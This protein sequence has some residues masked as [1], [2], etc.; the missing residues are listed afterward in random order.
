MSAAFLGGSFSYS[1]AERG[2]STSTSYIEQLN[3]LDTTNVEPAI[4]GLTPDGAKTDSARADE[5]AGSLGQKIRPQGSPR[6]GLRT[7][8][9]SKGAVRM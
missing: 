7:L 2:V 4:G 6:P 9:R 3:E 8:P 5:I 1:S